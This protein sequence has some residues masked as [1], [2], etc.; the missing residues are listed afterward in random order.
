MMLDLRFV[1]FTEK[2]LKQVEPEQKQQ[3]KNTHK[4]E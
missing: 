1:F 2:R 3:Q 4:F